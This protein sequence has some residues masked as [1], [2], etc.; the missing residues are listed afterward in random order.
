[1]FAT[2]SNG[3][4]GVDS[5]S[6]MQL[7]VMLLQSLAATITAAHMRRSGSTAEAKGNANTVHKAVK[8]K[9]FSYTSSR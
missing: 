8:S 9:S 2:R 3:F 4:K 5:N 1:M 6:S 7:G